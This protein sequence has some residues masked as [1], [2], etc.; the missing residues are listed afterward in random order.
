[1]MINNFENQLDEIRIELYE[2]TKNMKKEDAVAVI[3]MNGKKIAEKY[4]ITVVKTTPFL[5]KTTKKTL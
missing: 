4:G 2:R 3:N 5:P 1:M